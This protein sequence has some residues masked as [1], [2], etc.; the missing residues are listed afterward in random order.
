MNDNRAERIGPHDLGGLTGDPL[1]RSEQEVTH[2][3]RR[4]DAMLIL[5]VRNELMTDAAQLRRGIES[6][7]PDVYERLSYYERWAG[8]IAIN[9]VE[10]GMVTQEELDQRIA[11]VKARGEPA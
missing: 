4:V 11:A 3:E 6:L 10:K 2:W 9:L 1:D 5:L 8:S 7:A